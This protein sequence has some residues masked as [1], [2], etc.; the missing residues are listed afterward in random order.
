MN[1]LLIRYFE[2]Q[3]GGGFRVA[4]KSRDCGA[5]R[6]KSPVSSCLWYYKA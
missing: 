6:Q 4:E 2:T 1:I 3:Q 5:Q